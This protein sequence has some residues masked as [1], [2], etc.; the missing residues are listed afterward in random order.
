MAMNIKITFFLDVRSCSFLDGYQ[1]FGRHLLHPFSSTLKMKTGGTS[2]PLKLSTTHGLTATKMSILL[3]FWFCL[4]RYF[5]VYGGEILNFALKWHIVF[6]RARYSALY[7][8]REILTAHSTRTSVTSVIQ[9]T[10]VSPM[11]CTKITI[12]YVTGMFYSRFFLHFSVP[13]RSFNSLKHNC[14]HM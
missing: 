6:S 9:Q 1:C 7:T 5:S 10:S 8:G 2:E 12:L 11:E 3:V 14:N 13:S 4:S